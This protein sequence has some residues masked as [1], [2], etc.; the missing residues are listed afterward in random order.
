MVRAV[1]GFAVAAVGASVSGVPEVFAD[2]T[3][4]F[5]VLAAGAGAAVA[6]VD[7]AFAAVAASG[8]HGA[9]V[10]V[11]N[12]RAAVVISAVRCSLDSVERCFHGSP[13]RRKE[14]GAVWGVQRLTEK[15][16]E[17]SRARHDASCEVG[18]VGL[19]VCGPGEV[20]VIAHDAWLP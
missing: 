16:A 17:W 11:V 9:V 2:D 3:A 14:P 7:A 4:A 6:A 12:A 19:L 18:T 20:P 13:A 8:A 10:A 15:A 5:A 1:E